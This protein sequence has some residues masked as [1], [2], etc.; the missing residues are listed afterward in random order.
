MMEEKKGNDGWGR[1]G[2]SGLGREIRKG[3]G[4]RGWYWMG[5]EGM[6]MSEGERVCWWEG[7]IGGEWVGDG[8]GRMRMMMGGGERGW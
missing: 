1:E 6:V 7:E 4:E 2:D 8:W 3:G 5:W